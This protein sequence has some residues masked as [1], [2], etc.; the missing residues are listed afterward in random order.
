[1]DKL[2]KRK[3]LVGY[4][5]ES[6]YREVLAK[7][8]H[9]PRYMLLRSIAKHLGFLFP[10]PHVDP[11]LF[12][13]NLEDS[14]LHW[15]RLGVL[16]SELE[17]Q[18]FF[19]AFDLTVLSQ[20]NTNILK[21][22]LSLTVEPPIRTTHKV[23]LINLESDAKWQYH[24]EGLVLSILLQ[25]T[26]KTREVSFL[27]FESDFPASEELREIAS[28][29]IFGW[30]DKQN[31]ALLEFLDTVLGTMK[32]L[33]IGSAADILCETLGGTLSSVEELTSPTAVALQLAEDST[34]SPYLFTLNTRTL[35]EPPPNATVIATDAAQVPLVYSV[36]S[37]LAV[38]GHPEFS[39]DFIEGALLP[40]LLE[41][42]LCSE[43]ELEL[44][45]KHLQ[46]AVSCDFDTIRGLS[47]EFLFS[48]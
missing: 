34:R 12:N 31:E 33:A 23:A 1:M 13:V 20:V 42:S 17:Y 26:Y 3:P 47:E 15:I 30:Q 25:N 22:A 11:D 36:N 32:I 9:L 16:F 7:L 41:H 48:V 18:R 39:L 46:T 45:K 24:F 40:Y 4:T 28:L 43:E 6:I 8:L 29:V 14:S 35:R 38:H 21:Q 37:V 27:F 19:T 44:A 5:D 2:V 10:V